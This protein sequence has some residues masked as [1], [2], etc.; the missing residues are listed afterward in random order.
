MKKRVFAG[1]AALLMATA[2]MAQGGKFVMKG[3]IKNADG[4]KIYLSYGRAEKAVLDSAVVK[5][6]KFVFKGVMDHP[7]SNGLLY[8]GKLEGPVSEAKY[9]QFSLEP[10]KMTAEIDANDFKKAVIHGGKTQEEE[11]ALEAS[12]AADMQK[13][14]EL[15]DAYYEAEGAEREAIKAQMEPYSKRM[16]EARENFIKTHPD[17]Y[18]SP[19]YLRYAMSRMNY[20]ELKSIYDGF[21]DNVKKYGNC[22]DIVKEIYALERVQTGKVAPD[23]TANDIHGKPFTMS[24]LK[25]HVVIIDFW[26]S[27]CKP[28]R[29]SNPHMLELYKKY[30]AKGLEMVYVSDDDSRP[31]AWRK[32]VADDK[33]TGDG[34]HHVLRGMKWDRSKGAEGIDHSNDISNQYAIHYLPTKYL[35]DQQGR[36][37]CKIDEG[38][39][40][41]LERELERLL[42]KAEYPFTIKGTVAKAEGKTVMLTYGNR[43]DI[44]TATT[45]VKDGAFTF[46]GVLDNPYASGQ[47]ILGEWNRMRGGDACQLALEEGTFTVETATGKIADAV[48]KGGKAQDDLNAYNAEIKPIM[49]PMMAL[50]KQY[51]NAKTDKQREA[52]RKK[53]EPFS[54]KYQQFV[55]QYMMTHPDSYIS[56]QNLMM[57]M[58]DMNYDELKKVYWGFSERVRLYGDTKEIEEELT[59]LGN[60]QPG[61][62]AP[63]F[64]A[65]DIN[66]QSFTFSSLKGKVVILDFWASWCVPCRKSNPHMKALYEKYHDKGLDMVYVSDDDNN[67]GAWKKAVEKDGLVGE[68]FHHVLRGLKR[69]AQGFDKTNDISM[70]YAIHYLPTKYLI[71]REGK[72][73]C[74][75]NEGEDEKLDQM[76]AELLK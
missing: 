13:M 18:L 2:M 11:N 7:Y 72:I 1:A 73:V 19:Q 14:Q 32:A 56:A 35:I 68:G 48:I 25:G 57:E 54:T 5:K 33:L 4:E 37:V 22:Q 24:S 15:N 16:T 67:E 8:M 43:E 63:D 71:D 76:L 6:G 23:F 10:T 20:Q 36:I 66:G 74:K 26:A 34:F 49:E 42:G 65:N 62:V 47:I 27:W 51:G 9:V 50:D 75:I 60:I 55:H 53:M 45:V 12:M 30:R 17:S 69:T 21:S 29:Q 40:E 3:T 59:A 38:E 39:D 64:T 52:I 28:C 70:K 44:K 58:G 46:S 61:A 31:E 41:K